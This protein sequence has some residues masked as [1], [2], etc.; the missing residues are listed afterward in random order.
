MVKIL[1]EKFSAAGPDHIGIRLW[2][3]YEAWKG[4]FVRAMNA[5]GH[6]WFTPSRATLLGFVPRSGLRQATLIARMGTS[7]Q[8]VQQ[9]VDGLEADGVLERAAD[10][11]DRRGK[12]ICYTQR[13]LAALRD[14]DAI[15]REIEKRYRQQMGDEPFRVLFELLGKLPPGD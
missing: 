4:E 7:K 5:A 12:I 14:A 2:T 9:L 3:A 8:A 13:G 10:P 15:K 11:K 1:D 6:D